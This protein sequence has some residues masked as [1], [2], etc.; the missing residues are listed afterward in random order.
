MTTK[1][2]RNVRAVVEIEL[3]VPGEG[4]EALDA[5][6]D[7]IAEIWEQGDPADATNAV[8]WVKDAHIIDATDEAVG[9]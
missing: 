5:T 8:V 3:V 9:E 1:P 7:L 6:A 2:K 4:D